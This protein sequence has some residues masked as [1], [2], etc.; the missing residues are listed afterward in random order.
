MI[1][2]A[3]RR[4]FAAFIALAAG[5]AT[6]AAAGSGQAGELHRGHWVSS[7][8]TVLTMANPSTTSVSYVGFTE[9]SIRENI[10]TS[11]GG[12]ALRVRI[13]NPTGAQP[14]VVGHASVGRPL[15]PAPAQPDVDPATLHELTFGGSPSV[16]VYQGAEVLSDP[17]TMDV[18]AL[19]DLLVTLYLPGPTG[20]TSWHWQARETTYIYPGDHTS[21]ASG[22]GYTRTHNSYH[23]LAGL[24]VFS[25]HA[26]GAVVVLGDSISDGY[27]APF[28]LD[29][30]FPDYLAARIA[31]TP[32]GPDLGV[33]NAALS[34]NAVTHNGQDANINS[35]YNGPSALARLDTDVFTQAGVRTVLVELGINDILVGDSAD[36]VI[37]GLQQLIAQAHEHGLKVVVGT[38]MP[39]EGWSSWT[40]QMEAARAAV[41]DYI[42]GTAACDGVADFDAALRDPAYPT[43]LRADLDSGDHVHPNDT[44]LAVMADTVP[45]WIL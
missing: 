15:A 39:A 32:H 2:P 12:S 33:V 26:D 7:W 36:R 40:P 41:N 44:G 18:P 35:V 5:A 29:H 24:D 1:T 22:A 42:R 23:Y 27:S 3:K 43:K 17:L 28:Y 20:S 4:I 21:D 19:S 13:A 14:L 45:L 25:R 10:H 8:G 16:T 30:R 11:I 31:N 9:Q 38:L 6:L 37:A 34:G